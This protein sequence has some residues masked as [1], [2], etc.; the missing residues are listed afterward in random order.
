MKMCAIRQTVES[1]PGASREVPHN[2]Q[3]SQEEGIKEFSPWWSSS[4]SPRLWRVAFSITGDSPYNDQQ[5]QEEEIK[6]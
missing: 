4:S 2:D 6:E 5:S 1:G 3:Q